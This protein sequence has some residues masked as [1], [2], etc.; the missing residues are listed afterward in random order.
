MAGYY[1]LA[2]VL[3]VV[4]TTLGYSFAPYGRF[5]HPIGCLREWVHRLDSPREGRW[6]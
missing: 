3:G 2:L 5:H 4:S 6:T 1:P